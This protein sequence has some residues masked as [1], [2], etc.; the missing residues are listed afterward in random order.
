MP[1]RVLNKPGDGRSLKHEQ[2][3]ETQNS[4][5]HTKGKDG[6][7]SGLPAPIPGRSASIKAAGF[8]VHF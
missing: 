2:D 1:R 3:I 5:E 7:A 8:D 6:F 4:K